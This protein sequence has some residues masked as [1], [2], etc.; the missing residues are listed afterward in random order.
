VDDF[1][2]E[3]RRGRIRARRYEGDGVPAFCIP[4]LSS[5]SRAFL[6]LGEHFAAQDRALIAFDLRGRGQSDI[7]PKGTYGWENHA[8]DILEAAERL[9]IDTFDLVGHSMG[10]FVALAAMSLDR[11][12]RIRRLVLIDAAGYP[13]RSALAAIVASVQRLSRT[14][15]THD[16]YVNAIRDGGMVVPWNDMWEQHY[17]YDLVQDG[18]G[19][20]PRTS[21]EAIA[22]DSAYGASH[23]P[24]SL[25]R[26]VRVPALLMRAHVPFSNAADSFVLPKTEYNAFL[27]AVPSAEG[28]EIEA[29]HY[30][31]VCDP[32]ACGRIDV[33]LQ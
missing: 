3:L 32:Q 29:N 24:R 6:G 15:A 18:N 11:S 14:F 28:V 10:A 26:L 25:W 5:N 7:T 27:R 23:D 9:D 31:I 33:F 8:R 1:D 12:H 22:E 20:H 13:S 2:V 30:G 17:R 19:V 16:E 4:G 21:H